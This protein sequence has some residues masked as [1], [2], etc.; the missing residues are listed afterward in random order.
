MYGNDY[1]LQMTKEKMNHFCRFVFGGRVGKRNA[2]SETESGKLSKYP[3]IEDI[4]NSFKQ[5]QV[6]SD[7]MYARFAKGG[8]A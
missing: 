5:H 6:K 1:L 8:L 4:I 3:S 2:P 7:Q